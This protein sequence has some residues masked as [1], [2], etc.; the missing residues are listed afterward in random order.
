PAMQTICSGDSIT[1]TATSSVEGS[2]FIWQ[3]GGLQGAEITV[4]PNTTTQY[5]AIATSP[6]QCNS[7]PKSVI[8]NIDNGPV[9]YIS[10]PTD[11]LCPGE[12][13]VFSAHPTLGFPEP[14]YFW[15]PGNF[16][17]SEFAVYPIETTTY[18]MVATPIGGGCSYQLEWTINVHNPE[19]VI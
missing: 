9:S 16:T 13:W 7:T 18:T 17:G 2:T 8:V 5:T 3:P 4:S 12:E 19:V 6:Q 14:E 15:M 11:S 1:L 10:V